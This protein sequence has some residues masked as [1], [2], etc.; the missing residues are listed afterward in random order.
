MSKTRICLKSRFD[1]SFNAKKVEQEDVE[2]ML[3]EN[4]FEFEI[5]MSPFRGFVEFIVKDV[6][7]RRAYLIDKLLDNFK[8][9][10]AG[11]ASF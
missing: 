2:N 6:T 8:K 7:I 4:N 1:L 3:S 10:N 5:I 11:T 9:V